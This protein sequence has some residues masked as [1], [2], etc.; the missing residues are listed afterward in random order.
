MK[1]DCVVAIITPPGEKKDMS[2]PSAEKKSV[3]F[4]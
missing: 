1:T 3:L 2:E 4:T